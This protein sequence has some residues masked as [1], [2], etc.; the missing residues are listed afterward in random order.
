MIK[1]KHNNTYKIME[2]N[3]QYIREASLNLILINSTSYK[4]NSFI[5]ITVSN[6]TTTVLFTQI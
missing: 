2:N 5:E 6:Q 4:N 1:K 3:C